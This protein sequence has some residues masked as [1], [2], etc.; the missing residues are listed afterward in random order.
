MIDDIV[1]DESE[2]FERAYI[3]RHMRYPFP[4]VTFVTRSSG[5][6]AYFN[7]LAT[8]F[9]GDAVR[10]SAKISTHYIVFLPQKFGNTSKISRVRGT[11]V[12]SATGLAGFVPPKSSYRAYPY[13]GGIAIKRFEPLREDEE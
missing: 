10:C 4:V 3:A 11:S 13:K 5:M 12:V 6:T 9:W 7:S 1:I 8:P 2:Y